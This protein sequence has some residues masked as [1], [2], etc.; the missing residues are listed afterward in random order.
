MTHILLELIVLIYFTEL[1][2]D[3]L[4]FAYP[5]INHNIKIKIFFNCTF[6]FII[7]MILLQCI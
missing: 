4:W 7:H 1:K 6:Y 3:I 2:E 5:I